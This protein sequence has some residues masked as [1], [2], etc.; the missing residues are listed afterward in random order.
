MKRGFFYS[1]GLSR[2]T[3]STNFAPILAILILSV[4]TITQ[5][6]YFG[7]AVYVMM[8]WLIFFLFESGKIIRANHKLKSVLSLGFLYVVICAVYQLLG[9]SSA[10]IEYCVARPFL[11]FA[12]VVALMIIDRC[13]N[14]QQVRFLFHFLALAI[15]INIADNI[16]LTNE[17]GIENIAYQKLAGLMKEEGITGLNLGGSMFVN[18]CVFYACLMFMAFLKSNKGAEKFLFLIYTGISAYFIIF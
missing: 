15:A 2:K 1:L 14:E 9:I 13:D 3:Y 12:P 6:F 10:S 18:M 11:Y 8:S 16:R 7:A 5:K 4:V 17:Y